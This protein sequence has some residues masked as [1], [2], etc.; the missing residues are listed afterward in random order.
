MRAA[1]LVGGWGGHTPT[2]FADWYRDLLEAKGSAVVVHDMLEPREAPEYLADVDLITPI[3]SSDWSG[4]REEFGNMTKTQD[5]DLLKLIAEGSGIA[6]WHG[7]MGDAFCGRPTCH[8]LI[9]GQFVADPPGWPYN[10]LPRK[11]YVDYDVTI[12]KPDDPIVQG[13]TSFLLTAEQYDMLVD[14]SKD[15]LATTTFSGDD[16]WWIE[17]AVI[18]VAW[19]RHW[20]KGRVFSCAIGDEPDDLRVPQVTEIIRRGALSAACGTA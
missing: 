11:D 16:L 17:G 2:H 15:V 10:L 9:G 19:R 20:E 18:P 1:L 3:W 12:C 5:D 13:V 7:Q 6:G 8:F 14:P 4:H